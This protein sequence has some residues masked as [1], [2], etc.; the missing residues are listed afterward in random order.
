MKK[1]EKNVL[2]SN[3]NKWKFPRR[4]KNHCNN[5]RITCPAQGCGSGNVDPDPS[6][7]CGSRFESPEKKPGTESDTVNKTGSDP[8]ST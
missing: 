5:G 2:I 6:S 7:G 3:E 4:K 1:K 8:N